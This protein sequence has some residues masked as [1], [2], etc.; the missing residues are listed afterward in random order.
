M[1]AARHL[2]DLGHQSFAYIGVPLLHNARAAARLSGV[3]KEL[4]SAGITIAPS[5][6]IEEDHRFGS[7]RAAVE[8]VLKKH[9]ETTAIICTSDYHALGVLRG[10]HEIGKRVPADISVVSFN[11]NDFSAFTIPSITTV[12]LKQRDVGIYAADSIYQL[13]NNEPMKSINIQP[14][15]RIR[16]SSGRASQPDP[17]RR[18]KKEAQN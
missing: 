12:D 8:A 4:K 14:E 9:P 6:I 15:L 17:K 2:L 18:F 1:I 10:I 7:G 11:N 3:K 5:A 16:E 13:L